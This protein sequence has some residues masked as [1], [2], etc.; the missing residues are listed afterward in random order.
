MRSL[1]NVVMRKVAELRVQT[2][3]AL[4]YNVFHISSVL[5]PPLKEYLII[6]NVKYNKVLSGTEGVI[7][8]SG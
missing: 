4:R 6:L 7:S 1:Q 5:S 3:G 2:G 8:T